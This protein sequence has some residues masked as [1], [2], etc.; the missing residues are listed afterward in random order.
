MA[1]KGFTQEA[2][3]T[4]YNKLIGASKERKPTATEREAKEA[5][6]SQK[7]QGRKGCKMQR[8]NMAFTDSNYEFIHVMSRLKGITYTDFVN[9]LLTEYREEKCDVYKEAQALIKK[10]GR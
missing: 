6:E 7:T 9:E 5:R 4:V 2:T 1:K 10:L 3:G 8:I